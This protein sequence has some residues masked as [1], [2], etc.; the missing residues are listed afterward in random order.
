M[1]YTNRVQTYRQSKTDRKGITDFA[2][3]RESITAYV[4]HRQSITDYVVHRQST[5]L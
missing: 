3:H 1:L 4:V 2:V 5:N